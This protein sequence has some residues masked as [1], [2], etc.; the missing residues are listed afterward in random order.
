MTNAKKPM[1]DTVY[2]KEYYAQC[3]IDQKTARRVHEAIAIGPSSLVTRDHQG[4]E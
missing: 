3:R 4:D 1:G 2:R